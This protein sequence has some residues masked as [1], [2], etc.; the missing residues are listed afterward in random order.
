MVVKR[1]LVLNF[2]VKRCDWFLKFLNTTQRVSQPQK[3]AQN[4]YKQTET[5]NVYE[6]HLSSNINK[7]I[8]K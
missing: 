2:N 5:K 3:K 7:T 8:D 4:A 1:W 6:K